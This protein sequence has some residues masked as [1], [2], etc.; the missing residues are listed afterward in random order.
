MLGF[1]MQETG[2]MGG[3]NDTSRHLARGIFFIFPFILLLTYITFYS[4]IHNEHEC[5][6]RVL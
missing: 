5:E 2:W 3:P 1:T 6:C 4:I